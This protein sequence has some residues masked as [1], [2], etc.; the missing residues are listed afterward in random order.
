MSKSVERDDRQQKVL[1][2]DSRLECIEQAKTIFEFLG[3]LFLAAPTTATG[4]IQY[5]QIDFTD[6]LCIW[7]GGDDAEWAKTQVKEI[8]SFDDETPIVLCGD[9]GVG[10]ADFAA[11][12]Q[13]SILGRVNM[14]PSYA[15]MMDTLHRCKI[16][17]EQYASYDPQRKDSRREGKRE[18]ELFRSLVGTSRGIVKVRELMGQVADKD[19]NVLITGES[20]TGKEVIARNLHFHSY[21]RHKPFVPVNCGA[22]P[23]ELL[24]SELF[25]HEKGAFTGAISDRPGR[26]ELAK[27]GTLFLDEI[28]DMPAHMQ[29]KLLRVLQ[30]R[31]F[32]RVGGRKEIKADVRVIAATHRNLEVEIEDGRFRED[33]YYR[34]NVFPIE[35]PAL[36]RRREDIP[37][38]LNELILR[39]ENEKRGS[40]RFNHAAIMTLCQYDWPGNVRELA[41][42][43]ERL[44]ILFPY[45]VIA[46]E[47]LPTKYQSLVDSSKKEG[48]FALETT[49]GEVKAETHSRS[50][51]KASVA[52]ANSTNGD[53]QVDLPVNGIDLKH[54]LSSLESHLIQQALED[55]DGVVARAAEKLNIRRTTL[56]EKMKKYDMAS[57]RAG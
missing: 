57:P 40:I 8:L 20:G 6:V 54:Y 32:E 23:A 29:V 28:G 42:L 5:R 31:T 15:A 39:C 37:L 51:S 9:N 25:G 45:D 16:F 7:V 18:G 13:K 46:P 53:S 3:E 43:V 47:D 36:R 35:M 34:L 26:F 4:E 24:E 11:D 22:I 38:L 14:P 50:T 44:T 30:E 56:V 41:N 33:L 12:Q 17:R 27:G 55:C 52:V 21:R 49:E 2:V 48:D 19:V 10:K 1:M